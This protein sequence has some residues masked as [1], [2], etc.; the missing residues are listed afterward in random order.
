MKTGTR[1]DHE[2]IHVA[3]LGGGCAALT[4]AFELTRPEQHGRYAVTVY[5]M[6]FRLGGKGASGRR[7][8]G[9]I[10][11]HGLHLWMGFYENAFRLMRECYAELD[12]DPAEVPIAT[13]QDAFQ[14]APWVAV[15][16]RLGDGSWVPWLAHFP[17]GRGQPGDGLH[18]D[19]PFTVRGYLTQAAS[20][21]WELLRSV[22]AGES[23]TGAAGAEPPRTVAAVIDAV[24]GL[25]RCGPV[26]GVAA[27]CEGSALLRTAFELLLPLDVTGTGLLVSLVDTLARATRRRLDALLESDHAVARVWQVIDLILAILRGSLVYGLALDPRGFDAI[28]DFDW[29]DWLRENG[30]APV[31]LDSGFVRG[32]YDLAFAY[33]DG[34]PARPRLAASVALRG[35]LRMFFTYRGSL[36]YR[37]TAGMGDIVFAPLYQVLKR[38]GVRFEF[39]HRLREIELSP[40]GADEPHVAA[41]HFDVQA[42][43]KKGAEY[44]P[45]IEVHGLPCWPA[46]AD[47]A[48]LVD[49]ARLRRE[50]REFESPWETR[51][52]SERVLRVGSDFDLVVLGLGVG[53]VPMVSRQLIARSPKWRA[54]AQHSRSVATQALQLW[55]REDAAGLGWPHPPINLSGF[56]EPFDTWAD[57][58]HLLPMELGKQAAAQSRI[59]S[60]AYFCSPLPDPTPSTGVSPTGELPPQRCSETFQAEQRAVVR[61]NAVRFLNHEVG[62]LWPKAVRRGGG[63]RWELLVAPMAGKGA[64]SKGKGAGPARLDSQYLTANVRPSERY[65]LSLPGA[66]KFRLSPLDR[67][68]DNLTV[69]GD[70]TESGLNTGCVESAVMSGLLAAHALCQSPPLTAIVGYD[71]P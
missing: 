23:A 35:A 69:A 62:A 21:L 54:M 20:L 15:A 26:L 65:A 8:D 63:F 31:S 17:P 67:S 59:K 18:K 44:Q 70:W 42:R 40:E 45:L 39:F 6:G 57:M 11:E 66:Q 2:P 49:G 50:G 43:V 10:E 46:E 1:R 16:D 25:L 9:R 24:A 22:P 33:E 53:A 71:H 29:R 14:P 51:T 37:M 47:H 52:A 36:F 64:D 19:N 56:A 4:T 68:F 13:F 38:R 5:Q 60:I 48:Q 7:P 55:L 30:A 28:D 41:L 32:I 58:S 3:I 12:R 61:Q 27:L 34:D